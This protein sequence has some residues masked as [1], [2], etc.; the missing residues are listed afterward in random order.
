MTPRL[1]LAPLSLPDLTPGAF[2]RTAAQAGFSRVCLRVLGGDAARPRLLSPALVEGPAMAA[3]MGRI[4]SGEGVAITEIEVLMI[5]RNSDVAACE[6]MLA[7]GG[8]IGA[9]LLTV[10]VVD[11]DRGRAADRLSA[12]AR[13]AGAYGIGIGLEFAPSTRLRSLG[14]AI[15]MLAQIGESNLSVVADALHLTR[16]GATSVDIAA[17][18]AAPLRLLQLCDAPIAMPA[19]PADRLREAREERLVPGEGEIDLVA[20]IRAMPEDCA[21]SVEVPNARSVARRGAIGHAQA[22]REAA[23]RLF[24]E[25]W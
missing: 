10:C 18:H 21:F 9:Q 11:E 6:P 23:E 12:L 5:G 25:A 2:I 16:S 22:L 15:A 13:M 20:L 1:S 14:E 24:A 17:A 3:E 19:D 8:A 4:A 7:A